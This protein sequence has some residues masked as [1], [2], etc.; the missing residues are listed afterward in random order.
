MIKTDVRIPKFYYPEGKPLEKAIVEQD[1]VYIYCAL[2]FRK[3]LRR[4]SLLTPPAIWRYGA[5]H[6]QKINEFEDVT[7][8]VCGFPKFFKDH[9]FMKLDTAKTG[10]VTKTQFAKYRRF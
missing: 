3:V 8:E 4:H 2:F 7:V 9:L 5:L 10:K 1:S 6:K